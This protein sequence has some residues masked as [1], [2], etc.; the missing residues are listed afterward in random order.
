MSYTHGVITSEVA[1][2][3]IP[4]NNAA[5]CV[6]FVIGAVNSNTLTH[7][8]A[9]L[10]TSWDEYKA[11]VAAPLNAKEADSFAEHWYTRCNAGAAIFVPVG[12]SD[13]I[14]DCLGELD[15]A[16]EKFGIAPTVVVVPGSFGWL[17]ASA[18]AAKVKSF[19]GGR[20]AIAVLDVNANAGAT[21]S[22][23]LKPVSDEYV[24]AVYGMGVING[25]APSYVYGST[26]YTGVMAIVDAE[27][28][29]YPYAS[30]S[31]KIAHIDGCADV[32]E[33]HTAIFLNKDQA[34]LF[35]AQGIV[36]L[37][38]A[39]QGWI[40]WGVE[41][42]AFPTKTDV[43]DQF[44]SVRRTFEYLKN[45]FAAYCEPRVDM[46]LNRRQIEGVIKSYNVRLNG[47]TQAGVIVGGSVEFRAADNTAASLLNGY[48][49]FHISIAPPPPM[50]T[51]EG[52]F[53][54]DVQMFEN[55][56]DME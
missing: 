8:S 5:S 13:S 20:S 24:A 42:T 18:I 49:H 38:H 28:G 7:A 43:K 55:S 22:A 44:V 29:D 56:L 39:S 45:D 47:L 16:F 15:T 19:D 11:K 25:T 2:S 35:N 17:N 50:R 10:C 27:N 14:S 37:R 26:I 48:A 33:G 52:T 23:S 51:I 1:T 53:E 32:S 41:T 21:A 31:N 3:I 36:T 30:A 40:V 9:F 46:P 4:A 34:N 12:S 54:F 6:P